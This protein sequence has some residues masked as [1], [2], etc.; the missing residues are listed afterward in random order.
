[1]DA[2]ASQRN[3]SSSGHSDFNDRVLAQFLTE[4]D[5]ISGSNMNLFVVA[6]TNRPFSID[7]ALMRPGRFD[8]LVYVP[9]PDAASR[10]CIFELQIK[11]LPTCNLI[12]FMFHLV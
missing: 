7:S 1:M 3:N 12:L 2:I 4:I 6:A 10:T 9:L 8:R 5:G 11:K